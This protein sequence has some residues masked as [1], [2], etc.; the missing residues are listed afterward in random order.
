MDDELDIGQLWDLLF[1]GASEES[2]EEIVKLDR[3][4]T[5]A[6]IPHDFIPKPGGYQLVYYGKAG[7]PVP[8][9]GKKYG[10]GVGAICSAIEV[11]GSY[12]YDNDR[13]E[14]KGLLTS[15]ESRIDRVKGD[16]TAEDVF[17]RIKKH[18]EEE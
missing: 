14:I 16:L 11:P 10:A 15:E 8:P 5:E 1:G 13:I 3:M 7:R 9:E 17:A 6:E 2:C 12:G 4:L 18:W